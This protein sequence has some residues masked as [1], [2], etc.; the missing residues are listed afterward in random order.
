MV[1]NDVKEVLKGFAELAVFEKADHYY[2]HQRNYC[3]V[4]PLAGNK[5]D[6][7][8]EES[9]GKGR[10]AQQKSFLSYQEKDQQDR[11]QWINRHY[12]QVIVHC[13]MVREEVG[14]DQQNGK[15]RKDCINNYI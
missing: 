7:K 6:R 5:G 15:K 10:T 14:K 8:K 9:K 3:R 12:Q 11:N 2:Q 4:Y 13:V 1:L